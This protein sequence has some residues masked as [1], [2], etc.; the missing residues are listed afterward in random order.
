VTTKNATEA[1]AVLRSDR[2]IDALFPTS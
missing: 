1:L 2:P